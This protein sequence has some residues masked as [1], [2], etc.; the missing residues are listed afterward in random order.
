MEKRQSRRADIMGQ[1]PFLRME[2]RAGYRTGQ[3]GR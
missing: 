1:L 2:H 3:R